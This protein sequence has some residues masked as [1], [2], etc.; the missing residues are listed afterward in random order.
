MKEMN[1]KCIQTEFVVSVMQC[2][3]EEQ[4]IFTEL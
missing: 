1:E 2:E 4:P 3:S